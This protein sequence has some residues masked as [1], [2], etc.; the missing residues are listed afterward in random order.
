MV[1]I[2]AV[3]TRDKPN[4]RET[5]TVH[6][7]LPKHRGNP[8]ES[9]TQV[10][11]FNLQWALLSEAQQTEKLSCRRGAL[12]QLSGIAQQSPDQ[13]RCRTGWWHGPSLVRTISY[14][15]CHCW[16][17]LLQTSQT[18]PGKKEVRSGK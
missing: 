8:P 7:P 3:C 16:A 5:G 9:R 10:R 18:Q 13:E 1:S 12:A 2:D 4:E 6:K 15:P 17:W 14:S 11:N